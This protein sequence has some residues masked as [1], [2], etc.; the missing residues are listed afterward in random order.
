MQ[1]FE[2]CFEQSPTWRLHKAEPVPTF[3]R[4]SKAAAPEDT[5]MQM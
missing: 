5:L 2:H 4:Q 1:D 3:N